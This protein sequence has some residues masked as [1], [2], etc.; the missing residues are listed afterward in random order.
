MMGIGDIKAAVTVVRTIRED[1]PQ[2]AVE[3]QVTELAD[4]YPH[5]DVLYAC[6]A[7][8]E[9]RNNQFAA[10]LSMKAPQVLERLHTKTATVRTR[11][12]SHGRK[13]FLCD[14]CNK[15]QAECQTSVSNI[16][17]SDHAFISAAAGQAERER[18]TAQQS[19]ER[20]EAIAEVRRHWTDVV[21]PV[22]SITDTPETTEPEQESA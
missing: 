19:P 22:D 2:R 20:L 15:T 1:W 5:P 13:G 17:G 7:I 10:T 8:A 14:I 3:G 16:N 21:T 4:N 12:G 6:V 18:Q 9:D 11:T